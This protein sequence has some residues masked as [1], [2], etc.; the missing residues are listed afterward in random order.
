[1]VLPRDEQE[2]AMSDMN[3]EVSELTAEELE[4]VSGGRIKIEKNPL[5]I[6]WEIAKIEAENPG[7]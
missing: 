6:A 3:K 4:V 1:M 2:S 7:F 5:V